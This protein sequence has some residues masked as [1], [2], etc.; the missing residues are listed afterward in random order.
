MDVE[1]ATFSA[2]SFWAVE[3]RFL[4]VN[5]IKRVR[6]GYTGGQKGK[7]SYQDVCLGHTMHAEAVE[8]EY[9]PHLVSYERLLEVFWDCHDPTTVNRQGFDVGVQYRSAVF[10]HNEEQRE[11][12]TKSKHALNELGVFDDPI[13]TEITKATRFYVAEDYH[14]H[15]LAKLGNQSSLIDEMI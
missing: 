12:A 8:V 9:D 10:V 13:V 11:K 3:A 6:V 4:K 14:Q 1:R 2:G 5:G 7:P 15:Y